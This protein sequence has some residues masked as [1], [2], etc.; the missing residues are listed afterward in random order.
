MVYNNLFYRVLFSLIL[1]IT[2]YISLYNNYILFSLVALIYLIIIYECIRFFNN[3]FYILILY[4][5][6]S[7]FSFFNYY[8]NYHNAYLFNLFIFTIILFDTFS[9]FSGLLFG[10]NYIF[11]KISP[12]K[13]LEGYFGGLL[14]TNIIIIFFVLFLD[15][16]TEIINLIILINF[17]IAFS[18]FGDLFQSFF[19]RQNNIKN[20]SSLLPG[21]GGF[22]DRF[23]SF[24]SA[25]V[26]LYL[27]NVIYL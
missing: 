9:F 11:K 27:Y 4:L 12:K 22:F 5:L 20:S 14:I 7:F 18:I 26:F 15:N 19:K 10:K 17:I 2:Y 6:I 8:F 1:M 3:Y 16:K 21:H 24:V 13:T 25:I 23:D